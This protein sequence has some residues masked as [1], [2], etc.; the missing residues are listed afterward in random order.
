[1]QPKVSV[2]IP[3][4]SR[5][6][7]LKAAITSVLNQTFRDFELLVVDDASTDNTAEVV[8]RFDD[9]RIKLIRHETRKGGSGAR[10]TGIVNSKCDY[11]GFLD[12]DDEWTPEKLNLQISLLDQ[13]PKKVGAVYTGYAW[14]D[15]QSGQ[16]LGKRIPS[17]RGN[18]VNELLRGNC[19]GTTSTVLVR[20]ACFHAVGVFDEDLPSFQDY[21]MWLRI[22]REFCFDCI[23]QPLVRYYR[24]ENRISTNLNALQTGMDGMVRKYPLLGRKLAYLYLSLGVSYCEAGDVKNGRQTFLKAIRLYPF[25]PRHYFNLFLSIFGPNYFRKGKEAKE[26]LFGPLREKMPWLLHGQ[27]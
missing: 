19:V 18:L 13:A 16:L 25:E 9:A 6:V 11:I 15:R 3:T 12:D 17:S 14:I 5:A 22:A 1:L 4:H 20:R 21:D 7:Y 8:A 2:I 27:G 24:H 10:N 26:K 23:D